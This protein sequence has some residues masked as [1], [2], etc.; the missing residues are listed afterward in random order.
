MSIE[1]L[2]DFLFWCM[3]LN[4]ALLLFSSVLVTQCSSMVRKIHSRLFRISEDQAG[5]AL[6]A[7]L[8]AYRILIFFFVIIPWIALKIVAG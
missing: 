5:V 4:L 2:Q 7:F 8:S 6:Y 3:V 1:G